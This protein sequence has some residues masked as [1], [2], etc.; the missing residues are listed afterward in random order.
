MTRETPS[1]NPTWYVDESDPENP[2]GWTDE[3]DTFAVYRKG[4][5]LAWRP[6][7]TRRRWWWEKR[8]KGFVFGVLFLVGLFGWL[9]AVFALRDHHHLFWATTFGVGPLF[10][11]WGFLF[12][13]QPKT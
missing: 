9:I 4:R 1:E 6:I 12:G 3:G 8:I 13:N 11:V 10:W 5:E 2:F 7:S